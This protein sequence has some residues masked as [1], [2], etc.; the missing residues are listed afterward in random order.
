MIILMENTP[1]YMVGELDNYHPNEHGT[2]FWAVR[3]M[4]P[5]APEQF[6]LTVRLQDNQVWAVPTSIWN[7]AYE[8]QTRIVSTTRSHFD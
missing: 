7:E 4:F 3:M 8:A 2:Q 5:V 1:T 6:N